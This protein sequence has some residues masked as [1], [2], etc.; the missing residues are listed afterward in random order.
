MRI[1]KSDA[2]EALQVVRRL[3]EGDIGVGIERPAPRLALDDYFPALRRAMEQQKF[4]FEGKWRVP[5]A[6]TLQVTAGDLEALDARGIRDELPKVLTR[7]L[8]DHAKSKGYAA[9]NGPITVGI[10]ESADEQT[11]IFASFKPRGG[12]A[13]APAAGQM[14]TFSAAPAAAA[15]AGQ[16]PPQPAEDLYGTVLY[17]AP[18][19]ALEITAAQSADAAAASGAAP[20]PESIPLSVFPVTLG[21]EAPENAA[22]IQI[23]AHPE[24]GR[25][26][27]RIQRESDGR[28]S[29]TDL[30]SVNGTILN[31]K[32]LDPNVSYPVSS[33][34]VLVL[35]ER[36]RIRFL[37]TQGTRRA[38]PHG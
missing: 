34:S 16:Q 22:D 7:K 12:A 18:V 33:D 30:N 24:V 19:A 17:K 32:K 1:K 29:V 31:G 38:L 6:Y 28:F 11:R 20:R 3:I 13:P 10:E 25:Q 4:E 21:R 26:H 36:V 5:V 9:A 15:P 8:A 27:I 23:E 14:D 2:F 35:A 37:E